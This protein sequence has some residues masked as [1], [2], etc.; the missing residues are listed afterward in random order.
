MIS[1]P[2]YYLSSL[3][4]YM[5][6]QPR[7]CTFEKLLHLDTGKECVLATVDPA[8]D[9]E[10]FGDGSDI[11]QVILANRHE[12]DTLSTIVRFP[13]FVFVTRLVTEGVENRATVTKA[14]LEIIA[15]GEL[16]R[17]RHDA[18]HHAFDP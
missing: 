6:E 17:T 11:T 4:S 7:T 5:L 8:I 3:D 12:G 15:W 2:T 10:R 13:C 1:L 9:G 18:E 16:Y 14:D